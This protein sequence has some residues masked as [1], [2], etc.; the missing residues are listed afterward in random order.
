MDLDP[1]YDASR[2]L[3]NHLIFSTR[4][5]ENDNGNLAIQIYL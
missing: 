1:G 4:L 3:S 5:V 2:F